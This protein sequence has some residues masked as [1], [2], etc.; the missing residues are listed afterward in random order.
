MKKKFNLSAYKEL[1]ELRNNGKIVFFDKNSIKLLTYQAS[2]NKQITYNRKAD[3][4][5]LIHEYLTR[6]ITLYEFQSKLVVMEKENSRKSNIILENFQELESFSLAEDLDKF[7]SLRGR[8]SDLCFD[9]YEVWDGT[10]E[11]MLETELYDLVNNWYLQLQ[12]AFPFQNLNNRV[13]KHLVSRSFKFLMFTLGL[14][15][16]VANFKNF[17]NSF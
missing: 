9:Y 13:Y 3:Y 4:F 12:E 7:S 15:I 8:I 16:L 11:P 5:L 10:M 2:V 14:E 17:I 1:L 6:V